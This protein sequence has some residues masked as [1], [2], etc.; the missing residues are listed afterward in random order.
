MNAFPAVPLA[1]LSNSLQWFLLKSFGLK[2]LQSSP[3]L[4]FG[5]IF[6]NTIIFPLFIYLIFLFLILSIFAIINYKSSQILCKEKIIAEE[7]DYT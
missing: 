5:F 4:R 2:S 7:K 6:L 3:G 1:H